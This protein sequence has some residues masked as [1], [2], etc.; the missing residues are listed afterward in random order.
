M[1][2]SGFLVARR[3]RVR[4]GAGAATSKRG[5]EQRRVAGAKEASVL[6]ARGDAA[7]AA[8]GGCGDGAKAL[9]AQEW[10]WGSPLVMQTR[11]RAR[12][13]GGPVPLVCGNV[14]GGGHIQCYDTG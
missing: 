5:S 9:R 2:G 10:H 1:L 11:R 12:P 6:R 8:R 4:S 7:R 3:A 13:T 14:S